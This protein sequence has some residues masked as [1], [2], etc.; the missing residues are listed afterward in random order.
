[1]DLS[2][3]GVIKP[4]KLD[5]LRPI[6]P[7]NFF[8]WK[9]VLET[10]LS[11][12]TK[13]APFL[14][15]AKTW[16]SLNDCP[17]R[18]QAGE[19]ILTLQCL[20]TALASFG[21]AS[22]IHDTVNECDSM[23]YYYKRICELFSLESSGASIF[24]YHKL[25]KSFK[26]DGS[27]SYQDFYFELRATRY[28][29]LLKASANMDFKGKAW[30]VNEKMTPAVES[31]VV[32]DWL[33]GIDEKL[34]AF[35]EQ[36]FANELQ[37]VTVTDI[38]VEISKHLDSYMSEIKDKE[39]AKSFRAQVIRETQFVSGGSESEEEQATVRFVRGGKFRQQSRGGSSSSYRQRGQQPKCA[40][41]K[42]TNRNPNHPT[43]KCRFMTEEDKKSV[44]KAF[45][46]KVTG[47]SKQGDIQDGD[48]SPE[49]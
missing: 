40:I 38:Q 25:R 3:S 2:K 46:A 6:N 23:K 34:P 20:L 44:A 43:H 7:R 18:D 41:C 4:Q 9:T 35:I 15:P 13:Y 27:K 17:N 24:Q 31:G 36:K 5:T 10:F 33:E 48:D 37:S 1:M 49:D 8:Q 26:H 12:N 21:P 42:E 29:T 47:S 22:L 11:T 28:E 14:D 19:N 16:K 30:T 32:L 45:F 39:V